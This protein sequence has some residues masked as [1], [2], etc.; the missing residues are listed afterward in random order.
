[1]VLGNLLNGIKNIIGLG[2]LMKVL[3]TGASGFVGSNLVTHLT[4]FEFIKLGR[5]GFASDLDSFFANV[6]AVVHLAGKAHDLKKSSNPDEY[7]QVNY[8]LTKRLFE[9]F[10]V[11]KA[12]KFIFMSS[13]K[14]AADSVEGVLDEN[15]IPMPKTDYGKS[16]LAAENFL[17]SQNLP[18]GKSIFILRPCMIHGPK[19][20]GNLNL[21][22]QVVKRGFPY[23]LAAFENKRSF[24]SVENLCFLVDKL[25]ISDGI[26]SGIYNV[27]D[28]SAISTNR[29]VEI[30]SESLGKRPKLWRVPRALVTFLARI[31]DTLK[32]PLN[33]ERLEKLTENYIVSNKK[34]MK[35]LNV[36]LPYSTTDG[37]RQ[38]ASSFEAD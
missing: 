32:L 28:D 6:D 14:A 38:T 29:L 16:K 30:L 31:G 26:E 18:A 35:A 17:L 7:F 10:L 27:A 33:T 5:D 1:M 36:I 2:S 4:N 8:I 15:V 13:V 20:K 12:S 25:L 19:N 21:L 24:L 9:A 3:L 11:S 22:Y 37:L 34:I 23:P